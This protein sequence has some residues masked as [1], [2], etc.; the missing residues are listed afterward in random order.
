MAVTGPTLAASYTTAPWAQS[1]M[2]T[3]RVA[4][5]T[6]RGRR[7][8]LAA[9]GAVLA[10]AVVAFGATLRRGSNSVVSA[11][12]PD[13]AA[14]TPRTAVLTPASSAAVPPLD[15]HAEPPATGQAVGEVSAPI[16]ASG[17]PTHPLPVASR[18]AGLAPPGLA[19]ASGAPPRTAPVPSA[20]DMRVSPQQA[21]S[22]PPAAPPVARPARPRPSN[23][24][25]LQLQN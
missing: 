2:P 24:L 15:V 21:V 4:R 25:D 10:V 1:D 11:R 14:D 18:P 17:A 20:S 6:S 9:I 19:P 23:P 8:L 16:A 22:P 13:R 12:P 5:S 7:H 3:L